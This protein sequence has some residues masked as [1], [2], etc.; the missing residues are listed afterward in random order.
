MKISLNNKNIPIFLLAINTIGSFIWI[1]GFH[2]TRL[3]LLSGTGLIL[4]F[5][6][7]KRKTPDSITF[8][9]FW[10][11][12]MLV[13]GLQN[14]GEEYFPIFIQDLCSFGM[15]ISAYLL[16]D[17]SFKQI[18]KIGFFLIIIPIVYYA[19]S[20]PLMDFSLIRL[21]NFDRNEA[22]NSF[23]NTL[24]PGGADRSYVI[25]MTQQ[26]M[27]TYL[28]LFLLLLPLFYKYFKKYQILSIIVL[29]LSIALLL[30]IYY[31]K[32]QSLVELI[33][34]SILYILFYRQNLTGLIPKNSLIS[35]SIIAA[36][37]IF[38]ISLNA[39][40]VVLD[41]FSE[42][43]ENLKEFDRFEETIY[44]L[45]QF[46]IS[47]WIFGKGIGSYMPNTPGFSMMHIGYSNLIFKGGIVLLIYYLVQSI[48]NIIYCWQKSKK[49][50]IY[51][52]GIVISIYSMIQM[53]YTGGYHFY[54]PVVLTGLAM[55]SRFLFLSIEQRK[56]QT[57]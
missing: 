32:R 10:I 20:V 40:S 29:I 12:L 1:F 2:L 34:I 57:I 24:L 39:L 22:L 31:Q 56:L 49:Y 11:F 52:I 35:I 23:G 41:R 5:L 15:I 25:Y 4:L 51:N 30:T 26:L 42:L 19:Y 38:I 6:F 3:I 16:K 36:L 9:K 55:F 37:I 17:T 44:T 13:F 27:L 8:L 28:Y 54:A 14:Y 21:G 50:P 53:S 7:Y 18:K 48:K 33:L 43:N 46:S 45:S 47:D